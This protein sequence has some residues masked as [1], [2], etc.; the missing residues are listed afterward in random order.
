MKFNTIDNLDFNGKKVLI[1]VDMNVPVLNGKVTDATRIRRAMDTIN[2][3]LESNGKV[4]LIS[5]FGRPKGKRDDKYSLRIVAEELSKMIKKPVKFLDDCIG[6]EV[7]NEINLMNNKDIIMLENLRFHSEEEANDD[8]FA[9]KLANLADIYINDAFST[10]HRAHASTHKLSYIKTPYAGKLMEAEINALTDGLDNPQKPI[11]AIVG[12]AKISTK[13]TLLEN[14]IEKVDFLVLGGGMAN[15]FL[16]AQGHDMGKSLVES[17]MLDLARTIMDKA[18]LKNCEIILPV[19]ASVAKEFKEQDQANIVAID[20]I[21]ADDLMLD[22]GTKSVEYINDKLQNCKTIIWNGPLGVCEIKP[23]QSGTNAVADNV[24]KLIEDKNIIVVAG[25]GDTVS[26]LSNA[27]V[28]DKLSYV[29][30][31]GGAFLE[32]MEGKELPC[33]KALYDG[34]LNNGSITKLKLNI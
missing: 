19:D 29:S 32:W 13:I 27:G 16:A 18:K 11:A 28:I 15:T 12:G 22:I 10:T 34:Y 20:K 7:E 31:A 14:L 8:A 1:R 3:V 9:N 17:D 4:V 21:Q 23:F 25:G 24:V 33:I 5:H 2:K 6:K 30:T 26:A